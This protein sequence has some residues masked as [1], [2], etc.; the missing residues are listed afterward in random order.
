MENTSCALETPLV[1]DP[2]HRIAMEVLNGNPNAYSQLVE[3]YWGRIYARVFQLM[4][5]REDAEEITQDAFT[6]ALDRL[7]SFRWE[8][9]FSTWLYQIASNLARNRF[10]YWKRRKRDCSI[11]LETPLNEDG[12][13]LGD[14]LPDEVADPGNSLCWREFRQDIH[15]EL[16]NLPERHREIMSLRLLSNMSY[17]EISSHLAI[18]LGTVKSRIARARHYLGQALGLEDI[19]NL[20]AHFSGM[21]RLRA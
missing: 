21:V 9:S 18:P 10:W 19:T 11:P 17:E 14:L 13:C 4:G 15:D 6:R 5:N 12:C 20:Q 7:E 2:D 16:D 3:R 8:A 1:L